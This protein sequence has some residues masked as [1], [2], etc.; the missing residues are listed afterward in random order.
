MAMALVYMIPMLMFLEPYVHVPRWVRLRF[1]KVA[2]LGQFSIDPSLIL[3]LFFISVAY[4][5]LN[6]VSG[7]ALLHS[8]IPLLLV[9]LWLEHLASVR[10]HA[11]RKSVLVK[12]AEPRLYSSVR[13]VVILSSMLLPALVMT[14]TGFDYFAYLSA[15]V[16]LVLLIDRAIVKPRA[17]KLPEKMRPSVRLPATLIIV[18]L[19][20]AVVPVGI[21]TLDRII[22]ESGA[23]KALHLTS[24]GYGYQTSPFDWKGLIAPTTWPVTVSW[25]TRASPSVSGDFATRGTIDAVLFGQANGTTVVWWPE[26][27]KTLRLPSTMITVSSR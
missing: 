1:P 13:I 5:V 25:S 27:Q 4:L 10:S 15:W 24:Q 18:L 17:E 6:W 12:I 14:E 16:V 11:E 26:Q 7:F 22:Q 8:F 2:F 23:A 20:G 3:L 9:F 21:G 19:L